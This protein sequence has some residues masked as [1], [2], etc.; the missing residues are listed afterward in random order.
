MAENEIKDLKGY[1]HDPGASAALVT[2]STNLIEDLINWSRRSS[3]FY[4]LF[5]LACCGIELM[6]TGGPRADLD[7]FGSPRHSAPERPDDCSR[8]A[9]L[10]NGYSM[11]ASVRA[12][13]GA[14]VRHLDGLLR[15][16]RRPVSAQ[17]LG[18]KGRRQDHSG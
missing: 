10:Q 18:R 9:H 7:R 6:Q 12:N 17:L 2:T 1:A 5:G 15:Q 16:L 14:Q 4:L 13:G 8:D 11:Q 3:M